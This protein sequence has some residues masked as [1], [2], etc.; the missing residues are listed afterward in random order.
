[1]TSAA[2][3]S[4]TAQPGPTSSPPT[5]A[6]ASPASTSVSDPRLGTPSWGPSPK[7]RG[8]HRVTVEAIAD[9]PTATVELRGYGAALYCWGLTQDADAEAQTPLPCKGRDDRRSWADVVRVG[10]AP[11]WITVDLKLARSGYLTLTIAGT[12]DHDQDPGNNRRSVR[13]PRALG[14]KNFPLN[15]A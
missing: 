7:G 14:G 6:P 10:T 5:A 3:S 1:M 11:A 2:P 12:D 4:S 9:G 8:W 15:G 13:M